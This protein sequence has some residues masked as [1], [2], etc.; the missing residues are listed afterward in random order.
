[1]ADAGLRHPGVRLQEA[2]LPARSAGAGSGAGPPRGGC[3]PSGHPWLAGRPA[4]LLVP[5]AL[6]DHQ[7]PG[8]ALLLLWPLLTALVQRLRPARRARGPDGA[9]PSSGGASAGRLRRA[10]CAASSA[11]TR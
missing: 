8:V 4:C 2:R 10:R 5:P 11:P 1:V 9:P 7:Q 3:L 6:G